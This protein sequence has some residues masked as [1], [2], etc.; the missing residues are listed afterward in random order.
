MKLLGLCLAA[1]ILCALALYPARAAFSDGNELHEACSREEPFKS[2]CAGY[3]IGVFDSF[4]GEH[5]APAG[6]TIIQVHDV[7]KKYVDGHPEVRHLDA[8]SL[9]LTALRRAFPC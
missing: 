1:G 7:V 3:I 9:V 6:V 4:E 2:F 8:T 5:C